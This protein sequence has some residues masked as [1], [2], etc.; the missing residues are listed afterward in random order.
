MANT[1]PWWGSATPTNPSWGREAP[2]NA[3]PASSP[4]SFNI[5]SFMAD[6]RT[7]GIVRSHSFMVNI[8]PPAVLRDRW[9]NTRNIL[10]RCDSAALPAANFQMAE[11]Y[12]HGYGPQEASPHNVQFEPVN[13]TFIMDSQA[14]I[15]T[16][17][18]TWLNKIFNFNRSKGLDAPDGN[19][20]PYEMN[21]KDDYSTEIKVLIYNEAAE[22]IIQATLMA[23]YPMGMS[24]TSF[25][26]ATTDDF[27]RLNIPITYRDFYS[28]TTNASVE[29]VYSFLD[30]TLDFRNTN[31]GSILDNFNLFGFDLP[32]KLSSRLDNI[33]SDIFL[34]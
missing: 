2:V 19:Q 33:I 16:F 18:Y 13:L 26:W 1:T 21:Y 34:H 17:W 32:G 23:A 7:R 5:G 22:N 9:P 11:L 24:E 29:E 6:I 14:E 8:V 27:V 10:I 25:N 20:L 12:R 30:P 15:Y 28:Q 4:G 3:V 31:R